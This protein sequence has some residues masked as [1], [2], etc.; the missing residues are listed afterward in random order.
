MANCELIELD[1]L[2]CEAYQ[3]KEVL[4]VLLH[5]IIFQ[6]ALGEHRF[7]DCD[8]DLFDLSYVRCDSRAICQRVE[9]YAAA[10]SAALERSQARP[11]PVQSSRICVAFVERRTRPGAF[12]LFRA[13]EK[14]VWERWHIALTVRSPEQ[15]AL[16]TGSAA[17]GTMST[18]GPSDAEA[19]R[20]QQ[21]QLADTLKERL[22]AILTTTSARKEHIPPADGLGGESAAW[23]E[24]SS[25]SESWSGMDFF[26]GFARVRAP[27]F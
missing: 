26:K 23:F 13:D 4:K 17:S 3:T 6:R 11:S 2:E 9:E 12:G 18:L 25:D 16:E 20:R 7:C 24:V 14:V 10:F 15:V 27:A 21:Q 19:R 5:S 22:E 1:A 8:S